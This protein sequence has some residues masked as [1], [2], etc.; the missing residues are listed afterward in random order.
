MR[1][2]G[3]RYSKTRPY[4]DYPAVDDYTG[5]VYYRSEMERDF[6]GLLR[7]AGRGERD[8]TELALLEAD[9]A[10]SIRHEPPFNDGNAAPIGEGSAAT[11]WESAIVS[12]SD[13]P[14]YTNYQFSREFEE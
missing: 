3:K 7:K 13:K 8:R 9:H 10:A 1:T 6:A 2:I 11:E 12:P 14:D 4:G 5:A